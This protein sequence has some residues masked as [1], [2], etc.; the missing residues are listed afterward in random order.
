MFSNPNR[1]HFGA[2]LTLLLLAAVPLSIG[3][4]SGSS[5]SESPVHRVVSGAGNITAALDTFRAVL[6]EPLNSTPD[7][8]DGRREVNWDGVPAAFTNTSTFPGDFFNNTDPAGPNGRKRG[9]VFTT[10]G[11]GFRV[12]DNDLADLDPSYD[13]QFDDFSPA[14]TFVSVG[15]T[16]TDVTFKVPGQ[17]TAATVHGFGVV[18]S[19]VDRKG[20]ATMEFFSATRSLGRFEAP[21]YSQGF[22]FL[23][24]HFPEDDVVR[25]RI[26]SGTKPLGAGV[27][28]V[29]S[30]GTAD[31][32]AMDDFLYDEPLAAD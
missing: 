15:S 12:S 2:Y 30:G 1:L 11:T 16:V 20:S 31:L 19:D 14:R 7:E 3:C 28:D 32:V 23:G 21:P 9:S 13:A 10:P 22:S 4:D 5:N 26:V 8:T 29:S 24:V 18:F 6:G 17:N 27:L 25:V